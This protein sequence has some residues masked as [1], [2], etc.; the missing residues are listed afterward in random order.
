MAGK[1]VKGLVSLSLILVLLFCLSPSAFA[2]SLVSQSE[3]FYVADYSNVLSGTTE[4]RIVS[5]NG[6]LEEQCQDAQIVVVTVDYLS[7]MHCD[8]YAYELFNDWGVGSAEHNNG[9]LLLLATQEGKAWLAY[10]LGFTSLLGDGQV[11]KL[12]DEYFWSDFDKGR[13]DAAVTKLFDALLNWYDGVYGSHVVSAVPEPPTAVNQNTQR[14]AGMDTSAIVVIIILIILLLAVSSVT[15]R[16]RRV[17]R[18]FFR[19]TPPPPP[20]GPNY[21]RPTPPPPPPGGFNSGRPTGGFRPSAPSRP[22]APRPSTPPRSSR[23]SGGSFSGSAKSGGFSRTSGGI[24]KGGSFRG[25]SGRGGGG[26]SGGGG[27]RR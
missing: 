6:L 4:D 26:F 13:Y 10:G 8:E 23:P 19:P 24:S 14:R 16:V 5:Y 11:D 12:L 27:G 1:H 18:S 21:R 25:G 9:M 7:G 22:S 2:A 17:R 3:S 15:R 20:G